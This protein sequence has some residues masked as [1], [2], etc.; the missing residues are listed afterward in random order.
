MIADTSDM[1][2]TPEELPD[3]WDRYKDFG[4]QAARSALIEHYYISL[5]KPVANKMG[6]Q[7][8]STVDRNDLASYGTFGL[9]DAIEKFDRERGIKFETYA[10]S[11]IRGA[12][13]DELRSLDWV[14]RG[15]RSKVKE[16]D[17]AVGELE[18]ELG[19]T[20]ES[21][22]VAERLGITTQEMKSVAVTSVT[23]LDSSPVDDDSASL[24][25]VIADMTMDP[26][27]HA[28]VMDV[29]ER[30]AYAVDS[31]PE[32]SRVIIALYYLEQM[33]LG[34]IGETLGVTE[35]RVCQLHGNVLK[36]LRE[37]LD[38]A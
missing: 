34:E 35:S 20:P 14:P 30:V 15:V 9:I 19:R 25:D 16:I 26:E 37:A 21:S 8:S 6:S 10:V 3:F 36:S 22:E 4:D 32:R 12:I 7:L 11:R 24:G 2:L 5:V 23:A 31:L 29:M 28:A 33:T 1:A 27:Q 13:L 17:R 18:T 38:A